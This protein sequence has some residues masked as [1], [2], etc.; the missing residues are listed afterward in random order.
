MGLTLFV[1]K[2]LPFSESEVT[3]LSPRTDLNIRFRP[4]QAYLFGMG[5]INP[6]IWRHHK[7][8]VASSKFQLRRIPSS[9]VAL[10]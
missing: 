9:W 8:E 5:G 2:Y 4:G 7:P 6:K 10:Q 1:L 3:I